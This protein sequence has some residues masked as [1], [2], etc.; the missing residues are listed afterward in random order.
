MPS[1]SS[2]ELSGWTPEAGHPLP[3]HV[4]SPL[5]A[6]LQL[7]FREGLEVWALQEK[8]EAHCAGFHG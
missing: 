4:G 2:T 3:V 5:L 7:V 8:A 6:P 1:T